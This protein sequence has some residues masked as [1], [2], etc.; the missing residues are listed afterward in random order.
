M[1]ITPDTIITDE[2][3]AGW[4]FSVNVNECAEHERNQMTIT[5]DTTVTVVYRDMWAVIFPDGHIVTGSDLQ[6]EEDAW[7]IA[8]GWPGPS[9]IE[10]EKAKGAFAQKVRLRYYQSK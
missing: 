5:P 10:H 3:L 2:L 1:I 6:T 7:K 9:E 4:G 8:L